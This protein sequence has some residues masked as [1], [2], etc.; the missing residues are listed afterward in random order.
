[1]LELRVNTEFGGNLAGELFES[2]ALGATA[3]EYL[4]VH[5]KPPGKI[6]P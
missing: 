6:R 4:D 5:I 1:M 2:L 3:A